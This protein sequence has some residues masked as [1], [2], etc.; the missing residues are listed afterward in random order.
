MFTDL[1]EQIA[2]NV[3]PI[4]VSTVGVIVIYYLKRFTDYIADKIKAS[5]A[6]RAAINAIIEGVEYAQEAV[7]EHLK[8]DHGKL[9]KDERKMALNIAI[10]HAQKIAK[11]PGKD[12]LVTASRER[13]GGWVKQILAKWK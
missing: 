11:G 5:E 12:L 6:E 3:I 13:I 9:T 10:E 8:Q 2:P 1:W 4:V 7:V